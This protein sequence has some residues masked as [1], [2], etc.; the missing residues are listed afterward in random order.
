M[1]ARDSR[2]DTVVLG[3]GAAASVALFAAVY[4]SAMSSVPPGSGFKPGMHPLSMLALVLGY[5]WGV[6]CFAFGGRQLF[7]RPRRYGLFTI[8]FGA[9]Q[10]AVVR[11]I[12]WVL[13]DLRGVYWATA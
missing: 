11:L 7:A 4:G 13:M 1:D 9:L 3:C 8:G 10:L 2:F 12:E 6:M 5:G